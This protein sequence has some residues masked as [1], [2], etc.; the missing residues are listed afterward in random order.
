MVLRINEWTREQGF[1]PFCH[2]VEVSVKRYR[3]ELL[4]DEG[5]PRVPS[6]EAVI[7][8]VIG[9][10]TGDVEKGGCRDARV[11]HYRLIVRTSA[12]ALSVDVQ[13]AIAQAKDWYASAAWGLSQADMFMPEEKRGKYGWGAYKD[14]PYRLSRIA[15]YVTALRQWLQE[16]LRGFEAKVANPMHDGW[17]D[18]VMEHVTRELG[19]GRVAANLPPVLS[20]AALNEMVAHTDVSKDKEVPLT[21]LNQTR[22]QLN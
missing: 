18:C 16:Q 14:L 10:T 11:T 15:Q 8:F 12:C 13:F 20:D 21:E 17:V 9:M 2:V 7:E 19:R 4:A 6:L 22:V 3:L 5:V 1:E